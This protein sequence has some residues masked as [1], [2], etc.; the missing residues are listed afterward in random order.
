[1]VNTGEKHCSGGTR[2]E[3]EEEEERKEMIHGPR[4]SKDLAGRR[5]FR[6]LLWPQTQGTSSDPDHGGK[7]VLGRL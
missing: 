6:L 3:E 2:G 4:L 1:M 7:G 5:K